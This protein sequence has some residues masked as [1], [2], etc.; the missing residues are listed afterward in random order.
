M[1]LV[2][3]LG[4]NSPLG[5]SYGTLSIIIGKLNSGSVVMLFNNR[6]T[7]NH[8]QLFQSQQLNFSAEYMIWTNKENLNPKYN[9]I[10]S[11]LKNAYA[12]S[13]L[14]AFEESDSGLK[15]IIK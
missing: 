2:K 9:K 8:T 7:N 3:E 1:N 5:K 12:W 11:V 6:C 13:G 15:A 4:E 10:I 14:S